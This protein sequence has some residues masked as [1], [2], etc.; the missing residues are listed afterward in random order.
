MIVRQRGTFITAAHQNRLLK[1]LSN[2]N[3][4]FQLK[5]DSD[6]DTTSKRLHVCVGVCEC[7][8]H[9]LRDVTKHYEDGTL[10]I[11]ADLPSL[12]VLAHGGLANGEAALQPAAFAALQT[13]PGVGK[14][15]SRVLAL[16]ARP[17]SNIQKLWLF[18]N[19][20]P[21]NSF[22]FSFHI[23]SLPPP[24]LIANPSTE[25]CWMQHDDSIFYH[26]IIFFHVHPLSLVLSLLEILSVWWQS[27]LSQ[28]FWSLFISYS[29][30]DQYNLQTSTRCVTSKLLIRWN[31]C[32][33]ILLQ[34]WA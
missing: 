13:Y 28:L 16:Y 18:H 7:V 19:V 3:F 30:P 24:V 20:H 17:N 9:P 5:F 22:S 34:C 29:S 8:R 27:V 12:L 14:C 21:S 15:H 6:R 26:L 1:L 11:K 23:L 33:N 25:S 32:V 4:G 2:S 10:I 31:E